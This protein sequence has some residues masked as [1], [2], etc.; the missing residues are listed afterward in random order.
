MAISVGFSLFGFSGVIETGFRLDSI[1]FLN[2]VWCLEFWLASLSDEE[3]FEV[4]AKD[5]FEEDC[6][7]CVHL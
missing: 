2:S 4:L 5:E 1:L 6:V 7:S 3:A